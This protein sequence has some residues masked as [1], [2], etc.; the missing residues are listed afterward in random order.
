MKFVHVEL[1]RDTWMPDIRVTCQEDAVRAVQEL[2]K[3]RDRE[4]V[5]TLHMAT[6]GRVISAE[7]TSIGTMGQAEVSPAELLRTVLCTGCRSWIL[8][9]NHPSGN[10]EFSDEDIQMTKRLA[11]ASDL[12]GVKLS[13]HIVIG[14][15]KRGSIR[16]VSPDVLKWKDVVELIDYAAEEMI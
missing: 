2:V 1:K 9:H 11:M 10:I 13:D 14:G 15:D 5:V 4:M 12:L 16:E 3:D 6:N 8:I 7:I